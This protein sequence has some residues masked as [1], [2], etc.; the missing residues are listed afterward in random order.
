MLDF[1]LGTAIGDLVS[2]SLSLALYFGVVTVIST[3][4]SLSLL[5]SVLAVPS[6]PFECGFTYVRVTVVVESMVALLV[7]VY[8][9]WRCPR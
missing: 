2:M 6:E 8:T 1:Y 5:G 3:M 4:F 7:I 9:T